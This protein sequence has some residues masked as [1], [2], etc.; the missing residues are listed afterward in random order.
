MFKAFF[1]PGLKHAVHLRGTL[2]NASD[3]DSGW[4]VKLAIPWSSSTGKHSLFPG[5]V[6]FNAFNPMLTDTTADIK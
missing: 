4:S 6:P 2:H 5:K 1:Q 3:T